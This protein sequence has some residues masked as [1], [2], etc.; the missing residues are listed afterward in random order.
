[1]PGRSVDIIAKV[2]PLVRFPRADGGACAG[3]R[4]DELNSLM[5]RSQTVAALVKEALNL[6]LKKSDRV[7]KHKLIDG[8]LP[9]GDEVPRAKRRKFNTCDKVPD[10]NAEVLM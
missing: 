9:E 10:V 2:M 8:T 1:M 7:E 4:T 3:T 6:Q 5:E